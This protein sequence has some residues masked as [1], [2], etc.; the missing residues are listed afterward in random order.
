MKDK[1][2][3]LIFNHVEKAVFGLVLIFGILHVTSSLATRDYSE[4]RKKID[5]TLERIKTTLS[6]STPD[7]LVTEDSFKMLKAPFNRVP[8]TQLASHW[9]FY[10]PPNITRKDILVKMGTTLTIKLSI[11]EK[12][13][14]DGIKIIE[15]QDLV[16][17]TPSQ[18]ISGQVDVAGLKEG[19]AVI[20]Y[21]SYNQSKETHFYTIFYKKPPQKIDYVAQPPLKMNTVVE[22][23]RV[24]VTCQFNKDNNDSQKG[25]EVLG[26]Q[27][28]R[29]EVGGE[30]VGGEF[31]KL[32]FE[33]YSE[34]NTNLEEESED[35][36]PAGAIRIPGGAAHP[37]GAGVPDG[38]KGAMPPMPSGTG[39]GAMPSGTG[40]GAMPSGTEAGSGVGTMSKAIRFV[41]DKFKE[42][43]SYIYAVTTIGK[44]PNSGDKLVSE[45][46]IGKEIVTKS[47]TEIFFTGTTSTSDH[48]FANVSVRK[49]LSESEHL[50]KPFLILVGDSIG[51]K[52]FIRK[53]K[54]SFDFATGA[55]LIDIIPDV[56]RAEEVEREVNVFDVNGNFELDKDGKPLKIKKNVQR[57]KRR[58]AK[59]IVVDAKGR[60]IEYMKTEAKRT[61]T[62]AKEKSSS[63]S[64][65]E[66]MKPGKLKK[67]GKDKK[68]KR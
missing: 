59:I 24:V 35:K 62:A 34:T 50:N 20:E 6:T 52:T 41:D 51:R 16:K 67:P 2:L 27:L 22:R 9:H 33:K 37:E 7:K 3:A 54:Q 61:K 5:D 55:S 32:I 56:R 26:H 17:V 14:K 64:K 58:S 39:A 38:A 44:H 36:L 18:T 28:Y 19:K 11:V 46:V 68:K 29:K 25:V 53:K 66:E 40:A 45:K 48:Q 12:F 23:A 8:P 4:K 30:E 49:W 47:N 57:L 43:T 13:A 60:T 10:Y 42:D 15:G 65:E 31:V 1:I 63:L 21:L